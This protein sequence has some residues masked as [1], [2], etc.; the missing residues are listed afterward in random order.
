MDKDHKHR[1][2]SAEQMHMHYTLQFITSGCS[3]DVSFDHYKLFILKFNTIISIAKLSRSNL[4]LER[5]SLIIFIKLFS[6]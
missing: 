1:L 5:K 6:T 4:T 2:S 3:H